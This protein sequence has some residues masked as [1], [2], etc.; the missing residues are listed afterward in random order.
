[1]H[2]AGHGRSRGSTAS[3]ATAAKGRPS[4]PCSSRTVP[5]EP[6]VL[7]YNLSAYAPSRPAQGASPP[8]GRPRLASS[9]PGE[10]WAGCAS[11]QTPR[12]AV[13]PG[14]RPQALGKGRGVCRAQ[15]HRTPGTWRNCGRKGIP[16][17]WA[18]DSQLLIPESRALSCP[19]QD[20]HPSACLLCAAPQSTSSFMGLSVALSLISPFSGSPPLPHP[21]QS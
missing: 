3:R 18:P 15:V 9:P 12:E 8:G 10:Q 19:R 5:L 14:H 17:C 21:P 1:M 4:R 6:Y 11:L 2:M 7:D 16:S 13:A 20:S